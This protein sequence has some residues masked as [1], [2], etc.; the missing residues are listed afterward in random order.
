[1]TKV[2]IDDILLDQATHLFRHGAKVD[3]IT[4][5]YRRHL[6]GFLALV[7]DEE[8]TK[9]FSVRVDEEVELREDGHPN[10]VWTDYE[11]MVSVV[12]IYSGSNEAAIRWNSAG[13]VGGVEGGL[14]DL[15]AFAGFFG[16]GP[17]KDIQGTFRN[18][19]VI[20]EWGN[21]VF[22]RVK[23]DGHFKI[24]QPWIET[25]FHIR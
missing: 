21:V 24:A 15:L 6:Q 16:T 23:G 11:M 12:G 25:A 10:V 9:R 20:F 14:E 2:G 22:G 8:V 19:A 5:P 13:T 3:S 4:G 18:L 7:S 1:V 17:L